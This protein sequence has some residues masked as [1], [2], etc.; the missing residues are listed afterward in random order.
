VIGHKVN[1]YEVK[2]LLGEGGMGAVYLAEHPILNR[3]AAVKVLKP[4]FAANTELVQRFLNEARA[5]NAIHHPNIIDI[6]D[7]GL[8]PEGVPYMMMEFL[9]GESLALRLRRVQR[10]SVSQAV[11]Y[12]R[13]TASAVAAAHAVGIVHRDLKPDNLYMVPDARNP[14][15]EHVKVLDF[16]IAKLRPEFAP[17]TPRTSAGALLGTPAYMSPEQCMGK[18]T[19]IDHR[20]DIYALGIILY[21]MLCGQPPFLGEN[22]GELFLQ[23]IT[24]AP[25]PPHLL[26]PEVPAHLEA[27]VL[28]ALEKDARDRI[29]TM[30]DFIALLLEESAAPVVATM[31]GKTTPMPTMST[32]VSAAVGQVQTENDQLPTM[33]PRRRLVLL[34]VGALAVGVAAVGLGLKYRGRLT[35]DGQPSAKTPALVSQPI[36][37]PIDA[38]PLPVPKA[39]ERYI[40]GAPEIPAAD[41]RGKHA[42]IAA[43]QSSPPVTENALGDLRGKKRVKGRS[44]SHAAR[45][46]YGQ[47]Q[48]ADGNVSTPWQHTASPPSQPADSAPAPKIIKHDKF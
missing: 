16:G 26:C 13:Q 7:V 21:E 8:L 24:V 9:E 17:G 39:A 47:R 37:A 42:G 48:A 1:N 33:L 40:P 18:T 36:A 34:G 25:K 20:S 22:F 19:E 29:Q 12:A 14:G 32:L 44:H 11:A 15:Q 38:L 41:D 46:E 45:E 6:I 31:R 10:L 2:R 35:L 43:A 3:K 5:A 30:N 23:H 28:K 27:V 4:E